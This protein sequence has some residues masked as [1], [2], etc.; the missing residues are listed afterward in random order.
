MDSKT[1]L[2]YMSYAHFAIPIYVDSLVDRGVITKSSK[3]DLC[4]KL[5]SCFNFSIMRDYYSSRGD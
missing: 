1:A 2:L 3:D 5:L 4:K